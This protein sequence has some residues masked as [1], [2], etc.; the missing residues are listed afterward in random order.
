MP[1]EP[2][3]IFDT[4][5]VLCSGVVAFILAHERDDTLHFIGAWSEEGL[6]L[7]ARHGFSQADLDKTYIVVEN[8]TVLTRSDAGPAIVAHLRAPWRWLGAFRMLPKA[9]RDSAYS[10]VA[11][12][13]YRW[14]GQRENCTIVPM[15]QRHRFTGV[16]TDQ[17]TSM[18]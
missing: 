1:R 14:F 7:A 2:F 18:A 10:I 4:K 15:G 3:I 16:G 12:H 5:C 17:T 9:I 13:R 8:G 11:A 6:A